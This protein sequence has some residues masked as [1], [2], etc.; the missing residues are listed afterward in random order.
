M[1][2]LG[3]QESNKKF[4]RKLLQVYSKYKTELACSKDEEQKIWEKIAKEMRDKFSYSCGENLCRFELLDLKCRYENSK[5]W[6]VNHGNMSYLFHD[7]EKAFETPENL[8]KPKIFYP[9]T[10]SS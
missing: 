1:L 7:A 2:W 9:N 10:V 4:L 6:K 5:R 8:G 3:L